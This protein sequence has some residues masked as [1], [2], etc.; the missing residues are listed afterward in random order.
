MVKS[1]KKSFTVHD[2]VFAKVKGYPPWPA[3]ITKDLNKKKFSVIF[4]GTGE[5]ANVKSEDLFKYMDFKDK[6]NNEKVMKKP[7]YFEATKQIEEAISGTNDAA[8]ISVDVSVITEQEATNS[9]TENKG[10]T[11]LQSE[12]IN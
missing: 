1:N 2:Y 9:N 10:K 7:N 12:F 5:T 11:V 3:K 6:F 4:Y 8:P